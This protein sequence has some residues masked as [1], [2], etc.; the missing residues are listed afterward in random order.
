[1]N[2]IPYIVGGLV[3][4]GALFGGFILYRKASYT[5]NMDLIDMKTYTK[6]TSNDL[7]NIEK[8]IFVNLPTGRAVHV[9]TYSGKW[10]ITL[11]QNI[12]KRGAQ[13]RYIG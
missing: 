1:M 5:F 4:G 10:Y 8:V 12:E 6:A 2:E 11:P 7:Q 3:V 9:K 13:W